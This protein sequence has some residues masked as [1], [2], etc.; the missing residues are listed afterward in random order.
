MLIE[1]VFTL[2]EIYDYGTYYVLRNIATLEMFPGLKEYPHSKE[3]LLNTKTRSIVSTD[4]FH[5]KHYKSLQNI[6]I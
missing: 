3:K 1:I 4:G 6:R 5:Y 2:N